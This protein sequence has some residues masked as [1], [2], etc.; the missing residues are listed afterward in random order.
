MILGV[1]YFKVIHSVHTLYAGTWHFMVVK[2][3]WSSKKK[4]I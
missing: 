3:C 2:T 1:K 4:H